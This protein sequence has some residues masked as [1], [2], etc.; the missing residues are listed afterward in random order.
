MTKFEVK[1]GAV[2]ETRNGRRFFKVDNTLFD[3]QNFGK[4]LNFNRYSIDLKYPTVSAD[5]FDIIKVN[6]NVE[7]PFG[8]INRALYLETKGREDWTWERPEFILDEVEREYLKTICKPLKVV[9]ISKECTIDLGSVL[10]GLHISIKCLNYRGN[11][12]FLEFPTFKANR[13]MYSGMLLDREYTPKEL[14]LEEM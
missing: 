3:M 11:I 5:D 13:N 1:N 4:C 2:V 9:S 6:N 7:N 12:E 14:G 10:D 8:E